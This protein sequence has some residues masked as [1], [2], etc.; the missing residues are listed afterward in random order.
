MP[1][2]LT[3]AKQQ[4][5]KAILL[6][7]NLDKLMNEP[8]SSQIRQTES[9]LQMPELQKNSLM[10]GE[11]ITLSSLQQNLP[12]PQL[13]LESENQVELAGNSLINFNSNNLINDL[14]GTHLGEDV[15]KLGLKDRISHEAQD[16]LSFLSLY[17]LTGK[18]TPASVENPTIAAE[19]T[20]TTE[21]PR[22]AETDMSRAES[23][24]M[25]KSY[26]GKRIPE[27]LRNI[28]KATYPDLITAKGYYK[29]Y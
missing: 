8:P 17:S 2:K 9:S 14:I 19:Q 20:L 3:E 5:S 15:S 1:K 23:I 7:S 28:I 11:N 21:P 16:L 4:L 18:V 13:K 10:N 29:P 12:K 24:N 6:E 22:M 25:L 27:N 26:R